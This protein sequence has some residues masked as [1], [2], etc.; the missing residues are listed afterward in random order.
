MLDI[1]YIRNN[2]PE[3]KELLKRRGVRA[4]TIN[5][6]LDLDEKRRLIL[7]KLEEFKAEKNRFNKEIGNLSD[8]ERSKRINQLSKVDESEEKLKIKYKSITEKYNTV[9]LNIPN[10]PEHNVVVGKDENE[11]AVIKTV[12]E[13]NKAEFEWKSYIELAEIHD[14]I[15]TKRAAKIS[16]SRFGFLKGGGALL[17]NALVQYSLKV[18]L[19][20]GFVPFFSP[21]M[22]K[23]DVMVNSG[24][25][26]YIE[27][28]EAYFIERDD[29]YLVGTGEHTLLP[30]HSDE[31]IS[32]SDLPLQ[33]TTY[34]SCFR[35]EA[36]SYG[37][38]TK[39][40]L[41]VHQFEKQEMVVLCRPEDSW[42][43]F[44]KLIS[45]QEKI[46][47]GLGL[48][49]QLLEVCT[50]DLPKPSAKVI[51][52]ECWI[53]S[54][55]KY[56]ETHSASNCTDYQARRN[57]IRFKSKNSKSRYVHILNATGITPRTLI[58]IIENYQNKDGSI[59]TPE[60]LK[61][62]MLGSVQMKK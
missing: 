26:S 15:D 13:K 22:V 49:Y 12:G 33:Y 3:V 10:I 51:D 37:K 54:E 18:I 6:V 17:W 46:I 40:I 28:Q 58:A 24:Y 29:L 41:R 42:K 14:L 27:G 61:K 44:D 11:N 20:E 53:P 8:S 34:S 52:L 48:T 38:D 16:G 23:K 32:E 4:N 50:G 57:N 56:R 39:G 55:K 31:I 62:F 60:V 5:S 35:R 2:Q 7:S 25:N 1:K 59:D 30:Y 19:D 47:G 36:G 21:A 45:I 9:I 43:Q